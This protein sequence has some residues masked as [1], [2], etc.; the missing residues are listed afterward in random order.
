MM[1]V[2]Y[3]QAQPSAI[4]WIGGVS[5]PFPVAFLF[6]GNDWMMVHC[7]EL[8]FHSGF[9]ARGSL[10]GWSDLDWAPDSSLP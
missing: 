4:N 5:R 9:R 10:P 6:S 3:S 7:I 1:L 8:S 2:L